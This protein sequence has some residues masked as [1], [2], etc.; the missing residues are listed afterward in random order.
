[1][2]ARPQR[3]R[4]C[5]VK[6]GKWKK[7][8]ASSSLEHSWTDSCWGIEYLFSLGDAVIKCPEYAIPLPALSNVAARHDFDLVFAQG[9]GDFVHSLLET[10]GIVDPITDELAAAARSN[11]ET[12]NIWRNQA[13]RMGVFP[14]NGERCLSKAEWEVSSIYTAVVFQKK[15]FN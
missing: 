5:F 11:H 14:S 8:A 10:P 3:E 2:C 4:F 15:G 13:Q 9:F 6:H 1:M 12:P 7:E